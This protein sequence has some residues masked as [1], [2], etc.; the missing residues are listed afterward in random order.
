M[1]FLQMSN[2]KLAVLLLRF[3]TGINFLMHGAVRVFGDYSGFADGMANDFS[4]TFLPAFSVRLLGYAIPIIELIVGVILIVGY[5][6]RLGLV[7]G[8][9]LI[10]T[11][12]FG[13]SLLQEWG[14]VGSQMIYALGLFFIL[15][16]QDDDK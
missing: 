6:L 10:A 1:Q 15:Y 14:V 7:L 16:F 9:L 4:D 12:I 13:M 11:L 8:F 2:K 5:K 3:V